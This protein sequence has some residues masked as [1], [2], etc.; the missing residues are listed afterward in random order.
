MRKRSKTF[1]QIRV[2]EGRIRVRENLS[3]R[4]GMF[5]FAKF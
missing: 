4:E 1:W 5:A 2:R 3:V